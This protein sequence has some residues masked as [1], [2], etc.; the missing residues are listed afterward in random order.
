MAKLTK[1]VKVPVVIDDEDEA[2]RKLKYR[3]LGR[4]MSETRYLGNMAIRYAIA[5]NLEGIPRETDKKTNKP[6]PLDTRIYR[7]LAEK[8]KFL[9]SGIVANLSR[10]WAIRAF[11]QS[12]KEAWVGKK[13]LPTYRSAFV[14]FWKKGTR[15]SEI[16][17][18]GGR[19]FIIEPQGFGWKWLSDELVGELTNGQSLQMK[20]AQKKLRLVSIFS[21]KDQGASEVVHRIVTGEYQLCD[22]QLQRADKGLMAYLSYKFEPAQPALDP[23]KICGV[24]LG[25][26]IPAVC[27]V[28]FGPQRQYIGSG[29]DVWTARSKFRAERRREQRRKGLYS[30]T[31]QWKRSEK[32]DRWIHTYYH[33]LTRQVIKFC[34]KHSCG[35]I[36]LEDLA[37]LRQEDMESEYRRLL[38]IPSKFVELLAYKAK[39]AGITIVKVNPRNTS[40]RCNECGHIS[41]ENRKSQGTFVCE[42][43][44]DP[45]K[46]IN[47]DYNAARNIALASGDVIT[48]GY[49]HDADTG[50]LKTEDLLWEETR[51]A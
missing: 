49:T 38:W 7:I 40:R 45:K 19:Q 25:A 22:S 6:V 29:E 48:S 41:K 35:T 37:R 2:I 14:P 8:R 31:R 23:A 46:P 28:N 9:E 11:K 43:C 10:N 27:A 4:V 20:K 39:E 33:A 18:N 16:A 5:F 47:A 36:H 34:L 1:V 12:N 24:D 26:V 15:I 42:K 3:A 50:S 32:E 21:W 44:G 30:K 13:S 51:E 17:K